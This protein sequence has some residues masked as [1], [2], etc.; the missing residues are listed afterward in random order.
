[1]QI[2][3]TAFIA[4][5]NVSRFYVCHD[6]AFHIYMHLDARWALHLT[7]QSTREELNLVIHDQ[8]YG[9]SFYFFYFFIFSLSL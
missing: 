5:R 1:M 8:Q 6:R 7:D 9:G 4:A 3:A 2:T